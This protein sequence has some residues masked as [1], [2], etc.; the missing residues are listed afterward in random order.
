[1][2]IVGDTSKTV[3]QGVADRAAWREQRLNRERRRHG[4]L[5]NR[6][7]V[8]Q[9][10]TAWE[11]GFR[12]L[13]RSLTIG[14]LYRRGVRNALALRITRVTLRFRDLPAR[15][16]GL[17]ILQ[18]SD[19]HVGTLP[20]TTEAA[21]ELVR[22]LEPD[23]CVLTGDYQRTERDS[24]ESILPALSNLVAAISAR[25]GIFAILGNNDSA[26]LV[27][28]LE[29]LGVTVLV[30]E[31]VSLAR[32][33]AWLHMTGVDDVH[34]FFSQDAVEALSSTPNGFKIALVHSPELAETAAANGYRLYLTGHTHGGQIALPGGRPLVTNLSRC[35]RFARG[36]WRHGNLAG[37]TSSGVGVSVLPLR[38]NTRGEV[39]LLT[40]HR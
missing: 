15:F 29:A 9:P 32:G 37:F 27:A 28:P 3:L 17:T 10:W 31:T 1:M 26:A 14:G 39:A 16:D 34:T 11:Q 30:N 2:N 18:L 25:E 8:S 33:T 19:L 21:I 23:L 20:G 22:T 35:H 7:R 38:F 5:G 4:S 40:L 6:L 36:L 13:G 12:L 24:P